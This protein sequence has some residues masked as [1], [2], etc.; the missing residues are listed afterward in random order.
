MS[1]QLRYI[2]HEPDINGDTEILHDSPC[3]N[4]LKE[5][6]DWDWNSPPTIDKLSDIKHVRYYLE[7]VKTILPTQRHRY[8]D[9]LL[10][11]E[12]GKHLEKDAR[13]WYYEL[14]PMTN[15][16][17]NVMMT[18]VIRY[19]E[20]E[21][22]SVGR[23]LKNIKSNSFATAKILSLPMYCDHYS[24]TN[25][26]VG[27]PWKHF[28]GTTRAGGKGMEVLKMLLADRKGIKVPKEI[29]GKGKLWSASDDDIDKETWEDHDNPWKLLAG[30]K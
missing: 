13:G 23:L 4:H 11:S 8:S 17:R 18:S 7:D 21:T 12:F 19:M 10:R 16:S 6:G 30:V 28:L 14:T 3:I 22:A 25:H 27:Q 9:L 20:E 5:K 29:L 2:L 26:W 24:N 1:N 15:W